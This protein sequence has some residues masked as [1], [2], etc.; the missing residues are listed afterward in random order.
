MPYL[1]RILANPASLPAGII[2]KAAY[3]IFFFFL[4]L[5]CSKLWSRGVGSSFS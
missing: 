5:L 3:D 2:R 1:L 4:F